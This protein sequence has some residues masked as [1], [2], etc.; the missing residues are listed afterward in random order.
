M[1]ILFVAPR[2]H[3][4]QYEMVKTLQEKGHE[5]IFH[6]TV[7]GFTEDYTLLRPIVFKQSWVSMLIEKLAGS[8][9]ALRPNYFPCPV[10]Y[11]RVFKR[12]NPDVVIIRE[13]YKK[14]SLLAAFCALFKRSKI[15]FYTQEELFRYRKLKTTIKQNITIRFFQAAWM[16]PKMGKQNGINRKLKHMYYVPLPIPINHIDAS[17][18]AYIDIDVPKLLMIGKYHQERKRH[19]LFLQAVDILKHKYNFK[20][21][22]IGECKNSAQI[23]KFKF[24]DRKIDELGLRSIVDLEKN[25][26]F[27]SMQAVYSSHH[28][29]VLPSIDEPYSIS[30]LEAFGN[31]LPAI[32]TDSCGTQFNIIDGVNGFVVKSDALEKLVESLEKLLGNKRLLSTMGQNAFKYVSSNLSGTA[33]YNSFQH[34]LSTRFQ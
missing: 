22:I 9:G 25:V 14:F 24:L 34:V 28:I 13:P 3:T 30:V 2:F 26:P 7:N 29:F 6:A 18:R 5:V 27:E 8:G 33:F 20:A 12:I 21:T 15:I 23:E 32:C 11:W 1:I 16:T 31:G 19:F 10:Q 17:K 4:N